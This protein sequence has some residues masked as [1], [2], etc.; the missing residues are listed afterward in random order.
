M[1]KKKKKNLIT[2]MKKEL[3]RNKAKSAVLAV[4]C[5][6]MVYY[7]VP[8]LTGGKKSPKS[9]AS[10]KDEAPQPVEQ[11]TTTVSTPTTT[12]AAARH[13]TQ[14]ANA[15]ISDTHMTSAPPADSTESPFAG[16]Q[17]AEEVEQLADPQLDVA[18]IVD[19]TTSPTD[20]VVNG[21]MVG[22][23]R[24]VA[25]INGVVYRLGDFVTSR[26]SERPGQ[27][28]IVSIHADSVAV[29]QEGRRYALPI[30]KPWSA[31]NGKQAPNFR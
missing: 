26:D 15:I 31:A 25:T 27:Y 14:I 6:V 28:E 4:G 12:Q 18:E 13:W 30:N 10:A 9:T 3:A 21:V 7:W 11:T 20:L 2:M 24:S 29:I 17:P 22:G 16:F 5:I 1:K 23:T 8:L 19:E